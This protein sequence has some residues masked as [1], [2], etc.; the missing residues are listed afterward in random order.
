[1]TSQLYISGQLLNDPELSQTKK[2]KLLVKLVLET[3]QSRE[4]RP[5]EIQ[6]ESVTLPI[7]LF[8]HPAEQVKTLH[9]WLIFG[10]IN[11]AANG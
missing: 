4:V 11:V 7:T 3:Q 9:K 6:T 1:M 2:G 5:G 10:A 8:A